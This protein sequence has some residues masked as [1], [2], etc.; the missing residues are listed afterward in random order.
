V[1]RGAS[2]FESRRLFGGAEQ[3]GG[4]PFD[5]TPSAPPDWL[6]RAFARSR[7]SASHRAATLSQLKASANL[8]AA[9]DLAWI[10]SGFS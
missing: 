5:R 9:A 8:R 4:E 1:G 3:P 10:R 6:P 2:G 7:N